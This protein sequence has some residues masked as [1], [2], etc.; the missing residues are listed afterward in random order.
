MN[1]IAVLGSSLEALQRA[2]MILD[3]DMSAKI[4]IY[5]EDAEV[6]FPDAEV[7]VETDLDEYL[8]S[9]PVSYTHLTLPTIYSV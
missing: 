3:Q 4:M 5:T 6:G 8:S 7:F 1:Q 2:H 9:I